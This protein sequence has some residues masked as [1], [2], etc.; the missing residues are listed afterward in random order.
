[1]Y[2]GCTSANGVDG[3]VGA[4]GVAQKLCGPQ[5]WRNH[6][7]LPPQR[8]AMTQSNTYHKLA[9]ASRGSASLETTICKLN[10]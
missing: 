1:M 4:G 6:C 7:S 2:F 9:K 10:P 3:V 8:K 5:D